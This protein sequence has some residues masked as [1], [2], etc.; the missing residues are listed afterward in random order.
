MLYGQNFWEKYVIQKGFYTSPKVSFSFILVLWAC[1]HKRRIH[2]YATA[3]VQMMST[4]IHEIVRKSKISAIVGVQSKNCINSSN[5]K[6]AGN[7][8]NTIQR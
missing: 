4:R 8:S 6:T 5:S 2:R 3:M 1:D 7:V